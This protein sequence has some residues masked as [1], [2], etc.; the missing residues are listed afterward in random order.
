M[1]ADS[2]RRQSYDRPYAVARLAVFVVIWDYGFGLFGSV[3]LVRFEWGFMRLEGL[4][5]V[6]IGHYLLMLLRR[7]CV[8]RL[9]VR[10]F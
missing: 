9:E 7:I 2:Y 1:A 8:R 4:V 6:L 5:V 10:C 3:G